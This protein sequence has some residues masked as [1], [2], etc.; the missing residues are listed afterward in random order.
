[1]ALQR[2]L[3]CRSCRTL[4]PLQLD[5][6]ALGAE[7]EETFA[8]DLQIFRSQHGRHGLE[9]AART[10]AA[11]V[12]D[13]PPW[14]PM[15]SM[16]F[17]VR[18][19]TDTLVVRAWRTSLDEPRR[20]SLDEPPA[21]GEGSVEFDAALVRRALD[22]HF[23]PHALAPAKVERFVAAFGDLVAHLDPSAVETSFDDA[24]FPN[25]GI[26]PLPEALTRSLLAGAADIFDEWEL[27][28]VRSFVSAN[29]D[30]IGV[31][32]LRVHRP[33]ALLSA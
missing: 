33:L 12:H 27:E 25:A 7:E 26:A 14:D 9:E 11:S 13:R 30:E 22:R 10:A 16:W 1:M 24:D 23:F 3:L 31:L 6:F 20:Y 5:G 18:T 4:H 28:R 15:A 2:F 32:A 8:L 21:A 17:E 29:R 19:G